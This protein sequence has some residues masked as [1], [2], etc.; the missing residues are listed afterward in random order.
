MTRVRFLPDA[1]AEFLHEIE[2]YSRAR[3]GFGVK[4]KDAVREAANRAAIRP[5]AGAPSLGGTHKFR[6]KGF[7]FNL[8]YRHGPEEVLVVALAPDSK[9]PG[10]WLARIA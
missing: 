1:E 2:Y 4:F 9:R 6:V 8:Y 5:E 7:P 3:K 10:Y